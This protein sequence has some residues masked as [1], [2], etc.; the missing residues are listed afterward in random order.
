MLYS[1]ILLMLLY[2]TL[3]QLHTYF[4][5]AV[6]QDTSSVNVSWKE[7]CPGVFNI[8]WD[9]KEL[10]CDQ[11]IV[12]YNISAQSS[13]TGK[14]TFTNST[15]LTHYTTS[16]LPDDD[17]YVFSVIPLAADNIS[18]STVYGEIVAA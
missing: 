13:K 3:F 2:N 17:E 11:E 6:V 8:T 1:L 16:K 14:L 18:D 9:A 4:C 10:L 12:I 5:S 7:I 15:S